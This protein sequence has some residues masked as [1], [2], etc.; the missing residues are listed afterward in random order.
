MI[1]E[2]ERLKANLQF[3]LLSDGNHFLRGEIEAD[4]IRSPQNSAAGRAEYLCVG[5]SRE[6]V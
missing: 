1:Q 3:Q 4:E 5:G 2:I 6:R